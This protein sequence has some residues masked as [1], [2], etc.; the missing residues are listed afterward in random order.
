MAITGNK[1]GLDFEGIFPSTKS[2]SFQSVTL[3]SSQET[4]RQQNMHFF[5][6]RSEDLI[7]IRKNFVLC[8]L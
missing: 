7:L 2:F 5:P 3:S 6:G 4:Q 1:A 8:I